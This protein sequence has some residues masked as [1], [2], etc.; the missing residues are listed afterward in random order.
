MG[1]KVDEKHI[2]NLTVSGPR[3]YWAKMQ[4]SSYRQHL[5]FSLFGQNAPTAPLSFTVL[6]CF[7]CLLIPPILLTRCIYMIRIVYSSES[8][9]S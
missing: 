3:T 5:A 6:L 4:I 1:F 7:L 9:G 8:A 2:I